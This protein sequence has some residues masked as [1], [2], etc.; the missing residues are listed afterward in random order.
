MNDCS[1]ILSKIFGSGH[2]RLVGSW[3]RSRDNVC[4]H[5][6]L[7]CLATLIC[8]RRIWSGRGGDGR[9]NGCS[10]RP[11]WPLVRR[12]LQQHQ[13]WQ[14]QQHQLWQQLQLQQQQLK[15]PARSDRNL[16]LSHLVLGRRWSQNFILCR[17]QLLFQFLRFLL[18]QPHLMLNFLYFPVHDRKNWKLKTLFVNQ[19]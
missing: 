16:F 5:S 17:I 12:S 19:I 8:S 1:R 14:L 15:Q 10:S 4:I 13:L 11:W 6:L 2:N 9:L 7:G 3:F 18:L